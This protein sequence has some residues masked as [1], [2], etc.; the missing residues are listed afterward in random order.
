M[1][2]GINL[3]YYKSLNRSCI[4]IKACLKLTPGTSC[5]F[6]NRRRSW[7]DAW[8]LPSFPGQGSGWGYNGHTWI[9][10]AAANGREKVVQYNLAIVRGTWPTIS[11]LFITATA[12][13]LNWSVSSQSSVSFS[14][15]Y[16]IQVSLQMWWPQIMLLYWWVIVICKAIGCG[17]TPCACE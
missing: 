5:N 8:P 16:G 6:V 11:P 15:I 17:S 2:L 9:Q 1:R 13:L 12:C 3:R 14:P 4:W 7:I 10:T